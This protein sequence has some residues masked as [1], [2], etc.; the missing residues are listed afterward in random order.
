[1]EGVERVMTTKGSYVTERFACLMP[2]WLVAVTVMLLVPIAR[3]VTLH[4][5]LVEVGYVSAPNAAAVFA[6]SVT[7]LPAFMVPV[8]VCVEVFDGLETGLTVTHGKIVS[9]FAVTV[10]SLLMTMVH[11]PVPA[12]P[13]PDQPVKMEPL[14]GVAVRV[15]DVSVPVQVAPQLMMPELL[16]TS[17]D[18][19]PAL[20]TVNMPVYS[21]LGS[22]GIMP[23][24][25][26]VVSLEQTVKVENHIR[27]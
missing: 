26:A 18:P 6:D 2:D 16:A 3:L 23:A 13:P 7:V 10:A 21:I 15:R 25:Q 24:F 19:Y 1:M 20:L 9:K 12:Q 8:R 17:P 11:V 5:Q 4:C 27:A 22:V 14:S